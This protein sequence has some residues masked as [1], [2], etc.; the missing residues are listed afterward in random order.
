VKSERQG[1]RS[2]KNFGEKKKKQKEMI[3]ATVE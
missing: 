3:G 1:G 2:D